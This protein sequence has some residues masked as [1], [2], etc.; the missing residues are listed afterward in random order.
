MLRAWKLNLVLK[1]TSNQSVY[2]QIAQQIVDEI[3]RGRLA[4]QVPVSRP[5]KSSQRGILRRKTGRTI[6]SV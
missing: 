3:Q 6:E 1:R 2:L 5:E 4:P